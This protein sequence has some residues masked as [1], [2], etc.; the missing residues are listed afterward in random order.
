MKPSPT[1]I[2]LPGYPLFLALCFRLFGMENYI[3]VML[4]QLMAIDLWSLPAARRPIAAR[5]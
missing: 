1:L 2:R 5:V 4:V 3:A